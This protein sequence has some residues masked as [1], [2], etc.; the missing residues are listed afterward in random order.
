MDVSKYQAPK[1]TVAPQVET[2]TVQ[3]A[4][5]AELVALASQTMSDLTCSLDNPEDCLA[6][7]S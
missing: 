4:P 5:N 7:G 1:E 6:C 2:E 3:E